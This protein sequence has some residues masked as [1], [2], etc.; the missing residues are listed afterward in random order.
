[1][2]EE[3]GNNKA[4]TLEIILRDYLGAILRSASCR[5]R[6]ST[7]QSHKLEPAKTQLTYPNGGLHKG[8]CDKTQ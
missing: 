5:L 4:V 1:M 6:S 7:A 3:R 8:S 2:F